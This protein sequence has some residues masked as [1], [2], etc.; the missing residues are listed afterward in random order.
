V[1]ELQKEKTFWK[2]RADD[3]K[4]KLNQYDPKYVEQVESQVQ[5]E[6]LQE[7][8]NM[9]IDVKKIPSGFKST[10][11]LGL[12]TSTKPNSRLFLL[13]FF[14]FALF[15]AFFRD[16]L[17]FTNNLKNTGKILPQQ[18]MDRRPLSVLEQSIQ[19]PMSKRTELLSNVAIEKKS[20]KAIQTSGPVPTPSTGSIYT[21]SPVP[22]TT[23]TTTTSSII[24][25]TTTASIITPTITSS[26]S[27]SIP[28]TS[29]K[30]TDL[31]KENNDIPP[32]AIST[33][34]YHRD[35]IA[36][37]NSI[38]NNNASIEEKDI[39]YWYNNHTLKK[40]NV[41]YI[42]DNIKQITHPK[43]L[44]IETNQ[45]LYVSFLIPSKEF[46]KNGSLAFP[47]RENVSGFLEVTTTIVNID[48]FNPGGS[49]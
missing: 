13:V 4:E 27:T 30:P 10:K 17:N 42:F 18:P 1:D 21:S 3:F 26:I 5:V 14:G 36:D 19:Q 15:F 20:Q 34:V 45:P 2:K 22:T 40:N 12:V 48:Y 43:E 35:T 24:T 23:T 38:E 25:P 8:N 37:T 29:Q 46:S 33:M 49:I 16:P 44:P 11:V 6:I 28:T 9:D 41:Y 7:N 32:S 47:L 31:S 39:Q